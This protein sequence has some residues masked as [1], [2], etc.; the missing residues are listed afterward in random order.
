LWLVGLLVQPEKNDPRVRFHVGQ[1]IMLSI[2]LF[3]ASIVIGI[4]FGILGAVFTTRVGFVVRSVAW[5]GIVGMLLQ[6]AVYGVYVF[7]AVTSILNINKNQD[8]P[9]PIIGGMAFYK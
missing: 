8:K 9:L 2:M 7:F 5:I 6:L 4:I 1:G 3:G